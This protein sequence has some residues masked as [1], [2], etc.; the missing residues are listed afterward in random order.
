MKKLMT[1][2]AVCAI[3]S[4]SLASGGVTS[5]NVVGYQT[6][7]TTGGNYNL[8]AINWELVGGGSI[9]IQDL[10]G[11]STN[12]LVA[13]GGVTG[14]DNIK[15]WNPNTSGYKD[16]YLYTSGGAYPQW[17]GKWFDGGVEATGSIPMG[18]G[19]WYLSRA[20]VGNDWTLT[21]TKTY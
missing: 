7:P 11:G 17:D 5:A 15:V 12:G 10:F 8:L 1:A 16:Y 9:N 18:H 14:A 21:I 2:L 19:A 3:A 20:T 13:A 6:V 4:L